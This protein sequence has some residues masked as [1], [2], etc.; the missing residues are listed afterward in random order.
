M[1]IHS[2]CC[3]YSYSYTMHVSVIR[4]VCSQ[5]SGHFSLLRSLRNCR[6]AGTE[7]EK[8]KRVL[9]DSMKS[10]LKGCRS[11]ASAP[12]IAF[13]CS[14]SNDHFIFLTFSFPLSLFLILLYVYS[15]YVYEMWYH[16]SCI[17][18]YLSHI[19][20]YKC[21][22]RILKIYWTDTYNRYKR[23]MHCIQTYESECI[24]RFH[25]V[26]LCATPLLSP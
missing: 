21:R 26:F 16:C 10:S 6:C 19:P 1:R 15:K 17:H 13:L 25:P 5:Q 2:C 20:S 18:F 7:R 12:Q 8:N 9:C 22:R 23:C 4:S 11:F 3:S 14:V 24:S